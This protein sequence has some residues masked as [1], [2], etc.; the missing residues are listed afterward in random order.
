MSGVS[1]VRRL[2]LAAVALLSVGVAAC[3]SDGD[4]TTFR[5]YDPSNRTTAQV[6][7]ADVVSSSV[8]MVPGAEGSGVVYL[9]LTREGGRKFAILTR[10]LARRGARVTRPQAFAVEINGRVRSRPHV[11]YESFPNG[12]RGTDVEGIE[13]VI[14]RLA[15]AREVAEAIRAAAQ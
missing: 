8:R 6:T 9:R 7:A 12:I 4:R 11:D 2:G 1:A 3:R 13:I 10:A 5:I 15:E 14:P